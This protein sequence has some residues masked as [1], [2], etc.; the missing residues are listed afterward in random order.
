L[1]DPE[2][3]ENAFYCA[4]GTAVMGWQ[5]VESQ[6]AYVFTHLLVSRSGF[7]ASAVFYHIK[8]NKTRLEILDIAARLGLGLRSPKA[9]ALLSEWQALSKRLKS[10][11]DLRNKI[12]HS[13]VEDE[14]TNM[15]CKFSLRPPGDDFSRFDPE[16]PNRSRARAKSRAID[17]ST[18]DGAASQFRQLS[19]D[20]NAFAARLFA[21]HYPRAKRPTLAEIVASPPQ[22]TDSKDRRQGVR[23]RKPPSS[24]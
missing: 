19:S 22:A 13:M 17:S 8:N 14:I 16:N 7:A 18:V 2:K 23:R 9:K 15:G 21:Y 4:I 12:A 6:M 11:T 5:A 10:A 20:L 3:R 24:A 1:Y